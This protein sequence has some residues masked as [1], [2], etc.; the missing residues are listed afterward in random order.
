MS[1]SSSES[2]LLCHGNV[3]RPFASTLRANSSE[4]GR[5]SSRPAILPPFFVCRRFGGGLIP[6][7]GA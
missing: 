7:F 4:R 1:G 6:Y 2:A 5:F 3:E